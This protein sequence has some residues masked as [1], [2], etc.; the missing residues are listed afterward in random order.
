MFSVFQVTCHGNACHTD[1]KTFCSIVDKIIFNFKCFHRAFVMI[2][3]HR[4]LILPATYTLRRNCKCMR[5]GI[6]GVIPS[7]TR[8]TL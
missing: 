3:K 8:V 1:Y 6:F 4:K 2:T 5:G 7:V